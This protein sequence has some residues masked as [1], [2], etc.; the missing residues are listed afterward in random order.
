MTS[1]VISHDLA[2]TCVFRLCFSMHLPVN[3]ADELATLSELLN[4]KSSLDLQTLN[5]CAT[6]ELFPEASLA[7]GALT[8]T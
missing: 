8:K 7:G 5:K 4:C 1:S 6:H 2:Q 3:H